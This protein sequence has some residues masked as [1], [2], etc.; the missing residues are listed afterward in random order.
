MCPSYDQN[1]TDP[2]KNRE[3]IWL[4]IIEYIFR[5]VKFVPVYLDPFRPVKADKAA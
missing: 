5:M 4:P 2:A 1:V 3:V